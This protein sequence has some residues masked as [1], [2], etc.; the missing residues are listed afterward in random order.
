MPS[1]TPYVV[2]L[3]PA[4]GGSRRI[5][6]KNLLTL[7]GEPLLVHTIRHALGARRVRETI[8]ST[9]DPEIAHVAER[10]GARVV[11][12]P[13]SLSTD[14]A[15]S[16]SAL[17]HALDARTATG[18]PDPD[19]VVFLQ[20]TSPARRH[21]DIDAAID[22]FVRTG[23]DTLFSACENNR[24]IWAAQSG[25]PVALNYDYHR[26]Q[27]EQEMPR[28]FRENGSIY[29]FRPDVLRRERNRLGGRIGIYE[30][31]YWS[32]FQI[33]TPEHIELCEWIMRRPEFAPP[34]VW[35]DPV[36]RVIFDFDGVMTDNGV[37]VDEQ[38]RELARCNRGDGW[39][40]S[41]LAELGVPMVV[42][43]TEQRTIAAARAAKLGLKC[44][45]GVSDKGAFLRRY[46][47]DE[48]IDATGVVYVG[49]DVNDLPAMIQVGLPVAVADS[50]PDVLR[51]ARL[52]LANRG[53]HGAVREFC[54]RLRT[55]L[56]SK[57]VS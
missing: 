8:V 7:R 46:L 32:S 1:E 28:Q 22:T 37:W 11:M 2:A 43:S 45:H 35:P 47:A 50:H 12:R 42:V 49:N 25:G 52:V 36:A 48:Q 27:R 23:I 39:G 10:A 34:V 5:P 13:A 18:L 6:G 57:G 30:M 4:R 9:D 33:D 21:D 40:L 29:V 20:A 24:L 41:R 31:D 26:R 56:L 38:G 14:T 44:H 3:I 15:S 55:H 54:D 19:L 16:E 51:V 53:G 17:I